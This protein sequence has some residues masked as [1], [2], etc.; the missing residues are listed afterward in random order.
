MHSDYQALNMN[1]AN[2]VG[3]SPISFLH[4]SADVYPDY[5]AVI[6]GERRYSWQDVRQRCNRMASSLAEMGVGLGIQWQYWPLIP[7]RCS[8]H[9][10][11]YR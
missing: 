4:R 7:R 1:A 9:T 5:E 11:L 8:S 3:L 6:Y 10:F 2:Y